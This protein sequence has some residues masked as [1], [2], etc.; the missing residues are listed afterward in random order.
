[1]LKAEKTVEAEAEIQFKPSQ[2]HR[3]ANSE[4]NLISQINSCYFQVIT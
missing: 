3:E 1:M 4:S 2:S